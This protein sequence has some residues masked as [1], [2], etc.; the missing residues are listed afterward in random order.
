MS[1]CKFLIIDINKKIQ[2][3]ST[4]EIILQRPKVIPRTIPLHKLILNIPRDT[5]SHI[6][7]PCDLHQSSKTIQ[8]IPFTA[9]FSLAWFLM[10]KIRLHWPKV[11]PESN[12]FHKSIFSIPS[13]PESHIWG[14]WSPHHS[15][16]TTQ[17][18][19]DTAAFSLTLF[20]MVNSC[21][22]GPE[23]YL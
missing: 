8:N 20:Y 15:P 9:T 19:L 2:I 14:P 18:T 13:D 23:M 10:V 3:I 17:N 11:I 1:I 22:G 6:W 5:E 21:N 12:P 16:K 4:T 7:G